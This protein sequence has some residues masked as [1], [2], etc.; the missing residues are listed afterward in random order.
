MKEIESG[1]LSTTQSSVTLLPY[2]IFKNHGSLLLDRLKAEQ[3]QTPQDVVQDTVRQVIMEYAIAL[4]FEASDSSLWRRVFKLSELFQM[5]RVARFTL[6]T[7]LC[8]S[9]HV[10]GQNSTLL[11]DEGADPYYEFA[12][13][14]LIVLLKELDDQ[15]SIGEPCTA[16]LSRISEATADLSWLTTNLLGPLD[17]PHSQLPSIQ[18]ISIR[19]SSCNWY[20][21]IRAML[22]KQRVTNNRPMSTPVH[23]NIEIP[24]GMNDSSD[25][26]DFESDLDSVTVLNEDKDEVAITSHMSDSFSNAQHSEIPIKGTNLVVLG[27]KSDAGDSAVDWNETIGTPVA[28]SLSIEQTSHAESIIGSDV[29][30]Q[31]DTRTN[32]DTGSDTN[33]AHGENGSLNLS[34]ERFQSL[35]P[36]PEITNESDTNE[37]GMDN[38]SV[39]A[40]DE[41]IFENDT[42]RP[43]LPRPDSP[44][45]SRRRG[46]EEL[47][48]D[49][50][51]E[52]EDATLRASKRV[53]QRAAHS[54]TSNSST[55]LDLMQELFGA[56]EVDLHDL[57]ELDVDEPEKDSGDV[58]STSP[59]N[60]F[61][62][63]LFNDWNEAT[64]RS[65]TNA[66][67]SNDDSFAKTMMFNYPALNAPK[68]D[69]D[70]DRSQFLDLADRIDAG[71]SYFRSVNIEVLLALIG[72]RSS[73]PVSPY[74]Q[75][76]WSNQLRL[77]VV[78]LIVAEE[79]Q[80]ETRLQAAIARAFANSDI[81]NIIYVM[82][83]A[84]A[85]L[86]I[87]L[88]DLVLIEK[89]RLE[90]TIIHE[91]SIVAERVHRWRSHVA[92]ILDSLPGHQDLPHNL[93][94]RL[95]WVSIV[96]SQIAG[97]CVEDITR[98]YSSLRGLI[99]SQDAFTPSVLP[100]C[101]TL[102][103]ISLPAIE[104][105]ISKFS[106]MDFFNDV[107]KSLQDLDFD[108]ILKHLEPVLLQG[109]DAATTLHLDMIE[110]HLF[111]SPLEFRLQL[112][113]M[114][115]RALR[116]HGRA[117]DASFC[118]L[119][120]IALST[121]HIKTREAR[122]SPL[123]ERQQAILGHLERSSKLLCEIFGEIEANQDLLRSWSHTRC[124]ESIGILFG[125]LP[126]LQV[127]VYYEDSVSENSS[128]SRA[129]ASFIKL[130]DRIRVDL[131]HVW[132]LAYRTYQQYLEVAHIEIETS[133]QALA[134]LINMLH[135]EMGVRGYCS[136]A[137][138]ILLDLF[139]SEIFRLDRAET[140]IDLV[141]ILHC[142]YA[143]SYQVGSVIPWDHYSDPVPV[144]SS[145]ACRIL[146]FVMTFVTQRSP[147]VWLP[148][149]DLKSA[150]GK[151]H[152]SIW[153]EVIKEPEVCRIEAV[154]TRWIH[155]E[156]SPKDFKTAFC[157]DLSIG[158][159]DL[160]SYSQLL[161]RQ[162][163]ALGS[164]NLMLGRIHLSMY[165]AR[166]KNN[167]RGIPDLEEA[168]S[169]YLCD[170][171][172]HPSRV[173]SWQALAFINSVLADNELSFDAQRIWDRRADISSLQ[174]ECIL[175]YMMATSLAIKQNRLLEE[176]ENSQAKDFANL[177]YEFGVQIYDA[178]RAPFAM[179]AFSRSEL[180]YMERGAERPELESLPEVSIK[181]AY[182]AASR[183]LY[184]A[185]RE[186]TELWLCH[187]YLGKVHE[188]LGLDPEI[189]LDDYK[190]AIDLAPST[191]SLEQGPLLQ[192][193]YR[194]IS[195]VCKYL[196]GDRITSEIASH[197]LESTHFAKQ[198]LKPGP[199]TKA[200]LVLSIQ[201]A[202]TGICNVDKKHWHHR[203]VNRL[204]ALA[205]DP[206]LIDGTELD[207]LLDARTKLESLFTAKGSGGNLLSIWRPEHERPG[208]HYHYA[209]CYTNLYMKML[210]EQEDMEAIRNFMRRVRRA[211]PNILNHRDI[212]D[213]LCN[214][215]L[216]LSLEKNEIASED[217]SRFVDSIETT[218]FNETAN[219]IESATALSTSNCPALK[220]LHDF[221][222]LRK[223]NG[224]LYDT[225]RIDDGIIACY[226][227]LYVKVR[228]ATN[229][230][231]GLA[232][233]EPEPEP[234]P[235]PAP[236][237]HPKGV[238]IITTTQPI[239]T[240]LDSTE[241]NA[242]TL[243]LLTF[244][245]S[246][247]TVGPPP[248][249]E[250]TANTQ[251][252]RPSTPTGNTKK[253]RAK[254]P[255]ITR[256]TRR[257]ILS[258]S[259]A[260]CKP[261]AVVSETVG[262]QRNNSLRHKTRSSN[263]R[264]G[265]TA[266]ST[267]TTGGGDNAICPAEH[268]PAIH[269]TTMAELQNS[270]G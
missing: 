266:S 153:P 195:S 140:E 144:S 230:E 83:W 202:L 146:P 210:L 63:F 113:Q 240:L 4:S 233:G 35:S 254:E 41:E 90:G 1:V 221:Y 217:P 120:A 224:G 123:S 71:R 3:W 10:N 167:S 235:A 67:K 104:I 17:L 84:Q 209:Y 100:N 172:L 185:S 111:R 73:K 55:F 11:W 223:L 184:R 130:R 220:V 62:L 268:Q 44:S 151:L 244:M 229:T 34:E 156:I 76:T 33:V 32:S 61:K 119:K 50:D 138:G 109:K 96:M 204:A 74:L 87:S 265:S 114:L 177:L 79:S 264:R 85:I 58:N 155:Q 252:V 165:K 215:Y 112:W 18:A 162:W 117:S 181:E 36:M 196:L 247:P 27:P 250:P 234:E 253:G 13:E 237:P 95:A 141:Q 255:K 164:L 227:A 69:P 157:G 118:L 170:L 189:A 14:K 188:K 128:F 152:K 228:D 24:E 48:F 28:Q 199:C 186:C 269:D 110:Q 16:N 2:L 197:Y 70:C 43:V 105:E 163:D 115:S 256:V 249:E 211:V 212:W 132:I 179:E 126:L 201:A 175:C 169:Y 238:S 98:A 226:L 270:G 80:L 19:P 106:T 12:R 49:G 25:L 20:A 66:L 257:D 72:S 53:K 97:S 241:I 148:K 150:L 7:E 225:N 159:Q 52:D 127:F 46:A 134:S 57:L 263:G 218:V 26:T 42:F 93:N 176:V 92:R 161:G 108:S 267:G 145:H 65:A 39:T 143:I 261:K 64:L 22:E 187:L 30:S 6:E 213:T 15:F 23:F 206:G 86:E 200:N 78:K 183:C 5:V 124:H 205:Y 56:I 103:I 259:F 193:H 214:Q 258:R 102:H 77:A 232:E 149:P 198:H 47:A 40:A 171:Y 38:L 194:M 142:K 21:L 190:R 147:G 107:F 29:L 75:R 8:A 166:N 242:Q 122:S 94:V 246:G 158:V 180:K 262:R 51:D 207:R 245:S 54:C 178:A 131:L 182:Q 248:S 216:V 231:L 121:N 219:R 68:K 125:L 89:S 81:D 222:D 173:E 59:Y 137:K 239:E 243:S 174:R 129:S 99:L 45:G 260:L 88:D 203:P 191:S 192:P 168:Q 139:E 236:D 91:K 160:K 9:E 154:V 251:L 60:D 136:L 135:E 37:N 116:I 133:G 208:R 82:S 31:N 101:Q